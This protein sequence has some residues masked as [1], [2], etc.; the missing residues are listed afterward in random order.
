MAD[1]PE[2]SVIRNQKWW[3]RILLCV[4][5]CI[6]LVG[7]TYVATSRYKDSQTQ[8]LY[9][10]DQHKNDEA[11]IS[12]IDSADKYVYFAIYFFTLDDIADALIRAKQRGLIVWGL[13]DK[14]ASRESNKNIFEKLVGAG[15][16]VETQKHPEGIMHIKA[17]VT[18]KAYVSGSYNWTRSATNVN[19]EVLEI[20]TN[21][22]VHDQYFKILKRLLLENQ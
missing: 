3:M 6:A 8:V 16:A 5:V 10:L 20:G 9:S 18:D 22:S 11:I 1:T 21:K 14:Q 7:V 13:M 2:E 12:V 19:D 15:I 17:I 4:L